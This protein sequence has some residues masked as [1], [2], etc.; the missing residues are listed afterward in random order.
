MSVLVS[1]VSLI[2]L[3]LLSVERSL[4]DKCV[5]GSYVELTV[6]S[7]DHELQKEKNVADEAAHNIVVLKE[8][9]D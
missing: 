3:K 4:R 5:L 2:G 8:G 7:P 1:M 9:S 6:I